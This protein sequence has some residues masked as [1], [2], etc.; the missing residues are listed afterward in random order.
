MCIHET[1]V[2]SIKIRYVQQ[3]LHNQL[4]R[5]TLLTEFSYGSLL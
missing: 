4:E 1:H 2:K 3:G 5:Q